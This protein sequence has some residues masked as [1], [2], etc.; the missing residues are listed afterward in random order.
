MMIQNLKDIMKDEEKLAEIC[1][2]HA[3]DGW[4]SSYN[5]EVGYGTS[6]K[7]GSYF[8]YVFSIA[9]RIRSCHSV[10]REGGKMTS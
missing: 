4:L 5:N 2:I 10:S 1:G 6:I 7:E 9:S 3:G 8:N